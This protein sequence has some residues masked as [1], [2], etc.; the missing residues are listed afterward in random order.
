MDKTFPQWL[1]EVDREIGKLCG[2]SHNDLAD[3]PWHDWYD[4]E[5]SPAEAAESALADEGF[6]F[7]DDTE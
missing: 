6:P 4:D 1:K 7:G 2:L 3:Q 5:M